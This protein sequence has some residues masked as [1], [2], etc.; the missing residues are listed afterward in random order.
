L[1]IP[2]PYMVVRF[3]TVLRLLIIYYRF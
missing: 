3:L 2:Y 1:A